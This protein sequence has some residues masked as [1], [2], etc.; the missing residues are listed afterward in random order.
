MRKEVIKLFSH[1]I[2]KADDCLAGQYINP[3]KKGEYVARMSVVKDIK[4]SLVSIVES[5]L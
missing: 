3:Y 2:G 4:K 5:K 1:L